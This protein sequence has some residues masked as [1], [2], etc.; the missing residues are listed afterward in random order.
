MWYLSENRFNQ[1]L[2]T[3]I[4]VQILDADSFKVMII[5]L[6]TYN[7]KLVEILHTNAMA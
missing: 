6:V 5:K 7:L 2:W 4:K 3:I 1:L